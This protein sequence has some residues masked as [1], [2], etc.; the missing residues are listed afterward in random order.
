MAVGIETIENVLKKEKR[1]ELE[2]KLSNLQRRSR[3]ISDHSSAFQDEQEAIVREAKEYALIDATLDLS[4]SLKALVNVASGVKYEAIGGVNNDQVE[5]EIYQTERKIN[6][7]KRFT[8]EYTT[9]K[10][11]LTSIDDSL[12]PISF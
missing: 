12:K 4:S 6:N 3:S 8:T 1:A 9:Y 2:K 10:K 7:L 11:N 5:R